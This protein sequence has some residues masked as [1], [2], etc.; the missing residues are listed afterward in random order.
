MF[1]LTTKFSIIK[2]LV[3][4]N[5][6]FYIQFFINSRCNLKCK[7]C[8][9]VSSNKAHKEVSLGDI[10]KIVNNLVKI[11]A[12][13]VLLTGG[14]PFLRDDLPE[15]VKIFTGNGLNVRLQ[16]AGLTTRKEALSACVK[17]GAKD[18]CVSLD[19]LDEE[20]QDFING[21]K[22][23]W[24]KAIQTIAN[25]SELFPKKGKVCALGCVL[26]SYNFEEIP[27]IV[28][29][30][31]KIGWYVSL[32][33]VH[34]NQQENSY[35]FRSHDKSFAFK[36]DQIKLIDELFDKLFVMKRKGF[37]LFDS[38]TY[39]KSSLYFIKH[40]TPLW[41]KQGICDSPNLYFVILPNGD[42]SVCCDKRLVNRVSLMDD[43]F[44][45]IFFDKRFREEI[46]EITSNCA[47]CQYGSYPEMSLM[48]RDLRTVAERVFMARKVEKN[49]TRSYS[50]EELL[51]I[52]DEIK[53]NE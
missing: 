1:S 4:K 43:H 41:R 51:A 17:A 8:S 42:F 31:T 27:L 49:L 13:V 3:T 30:A 28:K 26:S 22:G 33:P 39:L 19:S 16:T 15:I 44:P 21:V 10:R 24:K 25:I 52:V 23:S 7:M 2:A 35:A 50:Y 20:K 37:N 48:V 47:G 18:I 32:V 40:G 38:E 46:H 14:E 6:P 29:F 34:I 53:K 5:S 36:P 45:E 9:I 11:G 12:G